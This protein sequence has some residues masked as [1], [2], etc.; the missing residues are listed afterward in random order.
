VW[1]RMDLRGHKDWWYLKTMIG[2]WGGG[3]GSRGRESGGWL[4]STML[5][6]SFQWLS[7]SVGD[8]NEMG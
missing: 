4:T 7:I 6:S 1:W 2:Y 8:I 3:G 5:H